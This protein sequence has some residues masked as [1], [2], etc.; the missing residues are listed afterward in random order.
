MELYLEKLF[1][2][3]SFGVL[4]GIVSIWYS[5]YLSRRPSKTNRL[6]FISMSNYEKNLPRETKLL[7]YN[8][9]NSDIVKSDVLIQYPITIKGNGNLNISE[10]DIKYNSFQQ[11]NFDFRKVKENEFQ[12]DFDII[13][14]GHGFIILII[15]DSKRHMDETWTD[16]NISG[17]LKNFE[18]ERDDFSDQ[19]VHRANS[20]YL[21]VF[22]VLSF[23][24]AL[25]AFFAR[26]LLKPFNFNIPFLYSLMGA[27]LISVIPVYNFISARVGHNEYKLFWKFL[28]KSQKK[29][30]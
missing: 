9:G 5:Y 19:M 6:L 3:P 7:I 23:V 25:V 30:E 8:D 16:L 12:I 15:H 29:S 10:V 17:L 24:V 22:I 4:L 11:G 27:F 28:K 26:T 20:I 18:I 1:S 13:K 14:Q 21:E 2:D